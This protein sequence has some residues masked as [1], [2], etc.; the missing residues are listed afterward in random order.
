MGLLGAVKVR[1]FGGD[2]LPPPK[3]KKGDKVRIIDDNNLHNEP[4]GSLNEILRD[5]QLWVKGD[6]ERYWIYNCHRG[7]RDKGVT[8]NY[9]EYDL[10]P[11]YKKLLDDS[12]FEME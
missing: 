9:R 12:L 10:E 11:V 1:Y 7:D 3:F 4:I 6:G 8:W 2:E 5:A